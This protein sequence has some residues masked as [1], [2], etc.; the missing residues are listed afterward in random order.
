MHTVI[1]LVIRN[2]KVEDQYKNSVLF[3][4]PKYYTSIIFSVICDKDYPATAI[5]CVAY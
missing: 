4:E 3:S 5:L 2:I 1:K